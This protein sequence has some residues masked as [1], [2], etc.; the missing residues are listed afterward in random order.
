MLDT[1][2]YTEFH[3]INRFSGVISGEGEI[4]CIKKFKNM[5]FKEALYIYIYI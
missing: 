4:N 2:T 5:C 1:T 3:N